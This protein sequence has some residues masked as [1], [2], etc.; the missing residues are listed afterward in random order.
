MIS[1]NRFFF[2]S[3]TSLA[4]VLLS[5]VVF[6]LVKDTLHLMLA[7]N[8]ALGYLPFL[9]AYI[10]QKK[11][12]QK[13]LMAV[14]LGLWLLFFPN[15]LYILTDF[16]YVDAA[17]FIR[18]EL[19][20]PLVYL[21]GFLAYLG[22]FH[23][24][25]GALIGVA[26]GLS[27]FESVRINHF[28]KWNFKPKWLLTALVFLLSSLAIYIG[29]FLR[30]NSWDILNIFSIVKQFFKGIDLFTLFFI[31]FFFALHWLLYGLAFL[32]VDHDHSLETFSG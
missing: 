30:F 3:L 12:M 22:L 2:L 31:L 25:F 26:L 16:I 1:R 20:Q 29:R 24:L 5:P 8:M 27:S 15:S 17:G 10:L 4:Y 14:L 32:F 11:K 6:F 9:F 7:W 18:A 21:R 23:I 13:P 19:Y 28:S